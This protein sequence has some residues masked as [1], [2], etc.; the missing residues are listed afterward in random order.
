MKPPILHQLW[1]QQK[2]VSDHFDDNKN[3]IPP[4]KTLGSTRNLID[5][6]KF[7][8]DLITTLENC[9]KQQCTVPQEIVD[10][11]KQRM[12]ELASTI[13]GTPP[14]FVLFLFF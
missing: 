12:S 9:A 8:N 5:A 13:L 6:L 14:L 1:C 10:S 4:S 11:A 7:T 2:Y 3:H